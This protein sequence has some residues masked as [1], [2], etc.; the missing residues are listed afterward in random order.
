M[1]GSEDDYD[2]DDDSDDDFETENLATIE[3]VCEDDFDAHHANKKW[4][5]GLSLN[6]YDY[7][8]YLIHIS[9]TSYFKYPHDI[10]RRYLKRYSCME[11]PKNTKIEIMEMVVEMISVGGSL[12]PMKKVVL[13]THWIRLIQ[14]CWRNILKRRHEMILKWGSPRNRKHVELTGRN[15][16]EYS[17]LPCL[18][19]CI[20]NNQ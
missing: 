4:F 3:G 1:S 6:Q 13:K 10:V 12:F 15:L 16:P 19:G 5:I 17:V 11:L 20:K 18:R 2:S 14:R 9:P 7:Y 8:L